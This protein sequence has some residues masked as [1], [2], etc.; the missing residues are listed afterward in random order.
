MQGYHCSYIMYQSGEIRC[1][2]SSQQIYYVRVGIP[3]FAYRRN[4]SDK[5]CD[6]ILGMGNYLVILTIMIILL[7]IIDIVQFSSDSQNWQVSCNSCDNQGSFKKYKLFILN[8]YLFFCNIVVTVDKW[9][10]IMTIMMMAHDNNHIT[11][12]SVSSIPINT[13]TQKIGIFNLE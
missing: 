6:L 8:F 9:T 1:K 5:N 4:I 2:E 3:T 13:R 10:I 11:E 7:A 12:M